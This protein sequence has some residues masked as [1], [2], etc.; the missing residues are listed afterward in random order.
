MKNKFFIG[1]ILFILLVGVTLWNFSQQKTPQIIK[2]V[3]TTQD[4]NIQEIK[5]TTDQLSQYYASYQDPYVI[6]LR[7]ALNGYLD[8]T[9]NG[10]DVP[11][12]VIESSKREGYVDGLSSFSKDYYKGKFIVYAMENSPAGGK[13]IAIIFQDKPDKLFR[14]W[15]YMLGGGSYDLRGFSQDLSYT[16]DKMETL[17][18]QYRF[19]LVNREHAL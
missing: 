19:I 13:D 8:G 14:A 18:K 12:T 9:N 7:T 3:P 11:E 10:M 6:A 2:E 4:K 5:F 17:Q 15:V 16:P 1:S